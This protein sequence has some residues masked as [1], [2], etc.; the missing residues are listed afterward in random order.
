MV[1]DWGLAGLAL[2]GHAVI[3][4]AA[5]NWLHGTGLPRRLVKRV[6]LGL[7]LLLSGGPLLLAAAAAL[8][9]V[10]LA[11]WDPRQAP[12]NAARA[13]VLAGCVA[14]LWHLPR[15]VWR[16]WSDRLPAQARERQSAWLAFPPDM[17]PPAL[18]GWKARL[19]GRLPGNQ[20]LQVELRELEFA[21]PGLPA[22]LDGLRVAHLSDLHMSGRVGIE[23]FAAMVEA[24]NAWSP[25]LVVL[26]GDICDHD[27]Q[28]DWIRPTLGALSSRHGGYLVWGNHDQ[29]IRD[30]DLFR[31]ELTAAGLRDL[32][33]RW[34]RVAVDGQELLLVGHAGPWFAGVEPPPPDGLPRILLAHTPDHFAWAQR[35]RFDLVLA[36]HTHGGQIRLPVLGPVFSPSKYGVRFA[37]GTYS[38]GGTLMHVSRGVSSLLPARFNCPGEVGLLVLR[39]AVAAAQ[40]A[41]RSAAEVAAA[42]RS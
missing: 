22:V 33:G 28:I 20:I 27:R 11:A 16:R 32:N 24:V 7:H 1:L 18:V 21:L 42:V 10:D 37:G 41:D 39:A 17:A 15:W 30:Q 5:I 8:G 40:G 14:A 4:V 13:Y 35:H 38:G 3:W 29:R 9:R 26:T 6:S 31:R 36:G 19:L 2:L 12:L 23:F 25:D 34:V